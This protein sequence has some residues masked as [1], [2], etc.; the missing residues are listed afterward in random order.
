MKLNA[1]FVDCVQVSVPLGAYRFLIRLRHRKMLVLLVLLVCRTVLLALDIGLMREF[2]V[3]LNGYLLN[4]ETGKSLRPSSNL[5]LMRE[6][7]SVVHL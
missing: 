2:L 3:L 1:F 5:F 7:P 4:M 6:Y